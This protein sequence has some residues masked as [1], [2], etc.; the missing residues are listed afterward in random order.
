M[1]TKR[2][3]KTAG[4]TK[5]DSFTDF[6]F[7]FRTPPRHPDC[8]VGARIVKRRTF[9]GTL[10]VLLVE[11][12]SL[13]PSA[14]ADTHRQSLAGYPAY[15]PFISAPVKPNILPILDNSG[16]MTEFAHKEIPV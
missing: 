1:K 12:C 5:A 4:C 2:I 11:F 13:P 8:L 16:S 9:C 14:L 6:R 7:R 15:P 10:P 3:S